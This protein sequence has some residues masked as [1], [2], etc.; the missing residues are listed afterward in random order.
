[1]IDQR[2][3][4]YL[5]SVLGVMLSSTIITA[6]GIAQ[7]FSD[8]AVHPM[9]VTDLLGLEFVDA[10]AV[11]DHG[12]AIAVVVQRARRAGEPTAGEG[13]YGGNVR[14]DVIVFDAARGKVMFR[15]SGKAKHAGY[16][17]PVWSPSGEY[18]AMLSLHADTM[19]VCIWHRGAGDLTCLPRYGSVDYLTQWSV[20]MNPDGPHR[21]DVPFVW[22]S[23][24]TLAFATMPPGEMDLASE[25]SHTIADSVTANWRRERLG[26]QPTVSIL[27]TPR[28]STER[29]G[30]AT[31]HITNVIH[32]T[33]RTVANIPF[34]GLGLR[35]VIVSPTR[36]RAVVLANAA[37][38]LPGPAAP[39]GFHNQLLTRLGVTSL[40]RDT[41][42]WWAPV[43]PYTAFARW[44]PDG[45]RFGV[46][47]KRSED[48]NVVRGTRL[49]VVNA[50]T[51]IIDSIAT[52]TSRD[53]ALRWTSTG[54]S[55]N[56]ACPI[57]L[58]PG[59]R[60]LATAPGCAIAVVRRR[61]PTE[62]AVLQVWPNADSSR[63][64]LSL[65]RQ[66]AHVANSRRML[67]TYAARDGSAQRGVVLL[68]PGYRPQVRY[69][70]IAW[71]YPGM[72]YVD[73]LDGQWLRDK[74]DPFPL[75]PNIL[76]GHG[77]AVLFPSMPLAPNGVAGEPY[78]H[79]LDGV[80]A[81]L[82]TLIARGIADSTRLGI[83]GQSYGGYAV[84]CI[85]S[86]S[87]RFRAAV[88]LAGDVDLTS[89]ALQ[90][91]SSSRYTSFPTFFLPWAETGQGRMGSPPWRDPARYVR[92]SPIMYADSVHT[93][94]LLVD[95][96]ND[97][98]E[99]VEEWFSALHR[100]GKRARFARYWGGEHVLYSPA[101]IRSLWAEIF[102]WL[103]AYISPA[104]TPA[105]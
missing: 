46:L 5:V 97:Y 17:R 52:S 84:N 96:D 72:L 87:H 86:Q 94:I 99:Q 59:D 79:M 98:V 70:V 10:A 48:E 57:V 101:N 22:L 39:F 80:D 18:L 50:V 23:D 85:V 44:A 13:L 45:N 6:S 9:T 15:T 28:P 77:Y 47:V 31:L 75:N 3:C 43:H 11:D 32:G 66:I 71:V 89:D 65:N 68:P 102:A 35:R 64:L 14:A 61:T 56:D 95:G 73:T 27:D 69:P 92:N 78:A 55:T 42:T 63:T 67:I 105:S 81:A 1:M 93:P 74:D 8:A 49:F 40:T 37:P 41:L 53:S 7:R 38:H 33:T 19:S 29:Y 91:L 20:G 12:S 30:S 100:A 26:E 34:F 82:D 104:E 83:L 16:W 21:A 58:E 103:D 90:F 51:R 88:S 2:A 25:R 76:A 62:T 36:R 60:I 54:A 24:S 4:R